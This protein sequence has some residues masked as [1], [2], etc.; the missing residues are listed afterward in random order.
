VYIREDHARTAKYIVFEID[1]LVN[2]HIVL[3]LAAVTNN[4]SEGDHDVLTDTAL[5]A[6][7][8]LA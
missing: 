6:Y 2:R 1:A 5:A 7:L 4:E 8:G 3:D